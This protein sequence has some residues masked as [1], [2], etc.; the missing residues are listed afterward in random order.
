[1]KIP[2]GPWSAGRTSL[3]TLA[4]SLLVLAACSDSPSPTGI[5]DPSFEIL[6]AA[7]GGE[8][9]GFYFLPPMVPS[10]TV[11]GEFD[12]GALHR[13]SVDICVLSNSVCSGSVVAQFTSDASSGAESVRV[14]EETDHFIVNWHT[15]Q[16]NLDP[17]LHYRIEVTLDGFSLGYAD[18]DLVTSGKELKNVQTGSYIALKDGRTLPIKFR[19]E[20]GIVFDVIPPIIFSSNRGGDFDIYAINP[21]GTDLRLLIDGPSNDDGGIWSPDGSMIAF[22]TDRYVSGNTDI[23]VLN[24]ATGVVTPV[25]SSPLQEGPLGWAPDGQ[26]LVIGQLNGSEKNLWVV[27]LDGS[28]LL[29]LTSGSNGDG[30]AVFAPDGRI[31][32]RSDPPGFSNTNLFRIDADGANETLILNWRFTGGI[33]WIPGANSLYVTGQEAL[34]TQFDIYR[35]DLD[36]NVLTRLTTNSAFDLSPAASPDGESLLFASNR[37]GDWDLYLLDFSSGVETPLEVAA[38]SMEITSDWRR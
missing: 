7:H 12:P 35:L 4:C 25:L 31:F 26:S 29:Q 32:F 27:N 37:T 24:V 38:G 11:T 30:P 8:V 14:G 15:D 18:V 36:G 13:L 1:M 23:A 17:S 22:N 34:G 16:F 28:G 21:D 5:V 33:E 20:T 10:P 9:E 2:N 6:D 19:V 3:A